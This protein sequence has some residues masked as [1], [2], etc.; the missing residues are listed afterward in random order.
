V[1]S[2]HLCPI[3]VTTSFLSP[4]LLTL[5]LYHIYAVLSRGFSKVFEKFFG[6]VS[7]CL[8]RLWYPHNPFPLTLLLYH[9]EWFLSRGFWK[10]FQK[11]FQ[12]IDC[13][14]FGYR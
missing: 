7:V 6:V 9:I 4:R 2:F 12:F 14:P 1:G 5:L 8:C 13:L 10:V 11:F 3:S